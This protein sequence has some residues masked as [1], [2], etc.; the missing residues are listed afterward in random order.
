[1]SLATTFGSTGR[2]LLAPRRLLPV[3]A[4]GG[5]LILV[6]SRELISE[7]ATGWILLTTV[8]V[9]LVVSSTVSW[10]VLLG[11]GRARPQLVGRLLLYGLSGGVAPL[12]VSLVPPLLGVPA[13]V[14][15]W[16]T[17]VVAIGMYWAAGYGL[18]RDIELEARAEALRARAAQT[19]LL[20]LRA[21]LDP[22]FLFNSLNAI[23][24]WCREDPEV[25]ER[26]LLDLSALLRALLVGVRAERWGLEQELAAV[27]RLFSIHA[28][29]DPERFSVTWK[30]PD[31]VEGQVLPMLL[32]PLA[33]NAMTH[34]PGKGHRGSVVVTARVALGQS[35]VTLE[36]PGAFKG[37]RPG[38]EGLE[39]VE[40]RLTLAY[41][42]SAQ[43]D[44]EADNDRTRVT[45]RWPFEPNLE[46]ES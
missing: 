30:V 5:P 10:R 21:H 37:R 19:E 7:P 39:T 15:T 34:G 27:R 3:L 23:A 12:L 28:M 22:H 6:Q 16:A 11:G 32:L 31:E 14:S 44:I 18:G 46:V 38:G 4:A 41:G 43:L 35:V 24:E 1:M 42:D 25:A 33:E 45:V 36:N 29:R 9:L 8:M 2:A 26:A 20:A 17:S 13:F 40:D